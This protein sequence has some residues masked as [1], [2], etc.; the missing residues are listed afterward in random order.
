[1]PHPILGEFKKEYPEAKLIAVEDAVQKK[2][3]EG[4]TFDGCEWR[5]FHASASY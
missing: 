5:N 4:L 3:T 1:M 2:E